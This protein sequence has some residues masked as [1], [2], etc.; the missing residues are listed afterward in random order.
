[1]LQK[2][3]TLVNMEV[4]IE[5][6]YSSKKV[7]CT[8][9]YLKVLRVKSNPL[10]NISAGCFSPNLTETYIILI[11]NVPEGAGPKSLIRVKSSV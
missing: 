8:V 11:Y 6:I 7:Q 2:V 4:L 3:Q 5:F 9:M 10:K 1:M